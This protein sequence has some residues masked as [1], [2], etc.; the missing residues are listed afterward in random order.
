MC[1]CV[2]TRVVESTW[3]D[4]ASG[5]K[6]ENP[7]GVS[8]YPGS[9]ITR[10]DSVCNDELLLS[11]RSAMSTSDGGSEDT[12]TGCD[13]ESGIDASVGEDD[14]VLRDSGYDWEDAIDGGA[15]VRFGG[16]RRPTDV[17]S[18]DCGVACCATCGKTQPEKKH[19]PTDQLN[20]K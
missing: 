5:L 13:G 14:W 3:R 9:G 7:S 17:V 11:T 2:Y 8:P 19:T 15:D 1:A 16:G 18:S 4:E 6:L 12:E 10:A 20:V